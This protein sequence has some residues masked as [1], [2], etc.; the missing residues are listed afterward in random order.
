MSAYGEISP[1][2]GISITIFTGKFVE[3]IV[4]IAPH[5]KPPSVSATLQFAN[6]IVWLAFGNS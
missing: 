3:T 4:S 5:E 6:S 1:P 2:Y